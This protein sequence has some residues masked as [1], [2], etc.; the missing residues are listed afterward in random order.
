VDDGCSGTMDCTCGG[1]LACDTASGRCECNTQDGAEP[2]DSP[3]EAAE[4]GTVTSTPSM[5]TDFFVDRE[6]DH[7]WYAF[8]I[9]GGMTLMGF[10]VT[11]TLE[12]I[13]SGSNYDL[14][15]YERCS[16]L[17]PATSRTCVTGTP[18]DD[19]AGEGCASRASGSGDETVVIDLP[20][21][22]GPG[23]RVHVEP[24]IWAATCAPYTL[25]ASGM[26]R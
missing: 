25:T 11:V 19:A 4:L 14:I 17:T 20:S 12:G 13:P 7:D 23:I 15:V 1:G 22:T 21:C 5:W 16:S 9:T 10:R 18:V 24:V 26:A 3:T 8:A 6:N 2:N